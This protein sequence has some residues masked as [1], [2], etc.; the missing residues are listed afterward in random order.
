RKAPET[1]RR[2]GLAAF[3]AGVFGWLWRWFVGAL[4]CVPFLAVPVV[5]SIVNYLT[6][7]VVVGW[8]YRWMQGL[9]LKTWWKKSRFAKEGSFR[10]YCDKLDLKAPASRPRWFWRER[11]RQTISPEK[12]GQRRPTGM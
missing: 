12:Y 8:M 6:G 10:E 1:T 7:A 3:V 9:A 2:S 11:I 5:G 4:F